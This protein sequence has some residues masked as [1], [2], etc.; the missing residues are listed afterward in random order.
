MPAK[1]I[2]DKQRKAIFALGK[3]FGFGYDEL[4]EMAVE[5]A[6]VGLSKMSFRQANEMIK[7]L[8][9]RPFA[10][11]GKPAPGQSKRNIQY[12]RQKAGIVALPTPTQLDLMRTRARDVGLD[13]QSLKSLCTT[14]LKHDWPHT[15]KEASKMI[16]ALKNMKA[17]GW[18]ATRKQEAA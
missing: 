9:G 16:E 14:T 13:E 2:T 11:C 3:P 18:K 6:G 1:P 17:R 10:V 4:H 15:S 12:K 7:H 5:L 8:K